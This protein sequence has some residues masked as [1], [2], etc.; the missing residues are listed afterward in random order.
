MLPRAD[1]LSSRA[2]CCCAGRCGRVRTSPH[3]TDEPAGYSARADRLVS[4]QRTEI[5]PGA[6]RILE[7]DAGAPE[8]GVLRVEH[9]RV[10]QDRVVR[11]LLGVK[12]KRRIRDRL[13]KVLDLRDELSGG[14]AI[15]CVVDGPFHECLHC[16]SPVAANARTVPTWSHPRRID[17]VGCY[18]ASVS[19][20]IARKIK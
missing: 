16:V 17:G 15:V 13:A 2:P 6:E 3:K 20:E 7:R 4:D 8:P 10:A 1:R 12:I 5:E 19:L 9:C 18:F 14:D 11:F